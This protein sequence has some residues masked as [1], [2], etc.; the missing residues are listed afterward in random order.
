MVFPYRTLTIAMSASVIL[1]IIFV[2]LQKC[3][4]RNG[5]IYVPSAPKISGEISTYEIY[6]IPQPLMWTT[7]SGLMKRQR[8]NSEHDYQRS[9]RRYVPK[10]IRWRICGPKHSSDHRP[11]PIGCVP[12]L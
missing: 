1:P 5:N 11:L 7:I 4:E 10:E 6:Q 12:C 2:S 3:R 8:E 9:L